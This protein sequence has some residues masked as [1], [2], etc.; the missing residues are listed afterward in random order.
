MNRR[1]V[2]ALGALAIAAAV[3][4]LLGFEL[5]NYHKGLGARVAIYFVAIAWQQLKIHAL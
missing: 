5:S 2:V 3:V 1:V 4:V